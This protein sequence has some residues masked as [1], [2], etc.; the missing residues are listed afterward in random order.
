MNDLQSVGI[1]Q[2]LPITCSGRL[3]ILQ[4]EHYNIEDEN[5]LNYVEF[6]A[7]TAVAMKLNQTFR[8][9]M[10][11]LPS[12]SKSKTSMKLMQQIT[13]RLIPRPWRWRRHPL[14]KRRLNF[15]GLHG[16]MS[17]KTTF[18]VPIC[19]VKVENQVFR[20]FL[21]SRRER[22]IVTSYRSVCLSVNSVRLWKMAV[23]LQI[24]V[25]ESYTVYCWSLP[26]SHVDP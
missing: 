22:L 19:S 10:S 3:M 4:N 20:N 13:S 8:R 1:Y 24:L 18:F 5:I 21:Q 12:R 16:V 15:V 26:F 9:N 14:S 25:Q 7:L 11:L 17:Q 23:F 6:R 2:C